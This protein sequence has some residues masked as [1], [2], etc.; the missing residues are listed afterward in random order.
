MKEKIKKHAEII[1][2]ITGLIVVFTASVDLIGKPARL[3]YIIS[4]IAGAF[5]AG[6][7]MGVLAAKRNVKRKNISA[8]N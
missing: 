4:I 2:I 8:E 5:A 3:V 1:Q 6:A 7:G